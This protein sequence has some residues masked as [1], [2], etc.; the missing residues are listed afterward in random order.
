MMA[1]YWLNLITYQTYHMDNHTIQL[2]RCLFT[3]WTTIRTENVY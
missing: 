2:D 3:N 1:D